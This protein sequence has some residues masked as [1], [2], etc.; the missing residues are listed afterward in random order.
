M[1]NKKMGQLINA[2][3]LCC[4]AN[5]TAQ[6]ISLYASRFGFLRALHLS[7]SEQPLNLGSLKNPKISAVWL[8]A[9]YFY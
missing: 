9:C 7:I 4:A 8:F 5:R 6:R 2:H 1:N 3:L